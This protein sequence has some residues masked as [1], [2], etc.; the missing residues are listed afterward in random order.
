MA[1]EVTYGCLGFRFATEVEKGSVIAL[2]VLLS[3]LV[4]SQGIHARACI[5]LEGCHHDKDKNKTQST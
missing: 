5:G 3:F 2:H 4:R 1:S